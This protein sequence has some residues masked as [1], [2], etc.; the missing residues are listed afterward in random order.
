MSQTFWKTRHYGAIQ[1]NPGYGATENGA[2][3]PLAIAPLIILGVM[4][5]LFYEGFLKPKPKKATNPRRR[6][7]NGTKKGQTRKTARKA[8][9]KKRN[10]TTKGESR[11]TA[12]KAYSGLPKRKKRKGSARAKKAMKLYHSGKARSLKAAWKMV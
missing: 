5:Y 7:R 4:G 1:L 6:R 12:R 9:T 11:K 8:Y 3:K 2:T 10:G